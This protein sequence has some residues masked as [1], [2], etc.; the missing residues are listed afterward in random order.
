MKDPRWPAIVALVLAGFGHGYAQTEIALISP[1]SIR[2]A[3]EQILPAF[4][5]K[6]GHTVK[7][8]FG[9][10][11]RNRQQVARGEVVFD[12]SILQPPYP[13]V[14]ASGHVVSNSERPL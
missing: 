8:T 9:N 10:G 7:V 11:G 13:E 12:V 6:T 14:L 3:L 2:P 4:E 1:A 5:R